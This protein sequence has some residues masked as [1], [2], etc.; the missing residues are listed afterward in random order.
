MKSFFENL[1]EKQPVNRSRAL[2]RS[3]KPRQRALNIQQSFQ[4]ICLK[5][6]FLKNNHCDKYALCSVLLFTD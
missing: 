2:L 1:S 5:E 3:K 4:H 6:Y